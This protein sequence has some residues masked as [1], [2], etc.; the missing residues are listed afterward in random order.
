LKACETDYIGVSID[1]A[2]KLHDYFR[3]LPGAYNRAL[4]GI[5]NSQEAGLKTGVRFT[6]N[7]INAPDLPK[8]LDMCIEEQIPRFCMYHL[9]YSD[10]ELFGKAGYR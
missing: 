9:V 2:K 10:G 1:G 4:Q 8:V 7:Q 6:I 5:R 3:N